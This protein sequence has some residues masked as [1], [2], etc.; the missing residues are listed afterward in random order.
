MTY[1]IAGIPFDF[2]ERV[3]IMGIL[4]VTPDSFSDG[5]SYPDA[6][7]A[8]ARGLRLAEEGA[9]L[10]D[11]GGESTRPGADPVDPAEEARRVVPVI[12]ELAAKAGVPVSVDTRNASVAREALDAG[13]AIV[14]DVSGFT[15]DEGM[16]RLVGERGATAVVMHMKGDPRTMQ[17]H[18]EYDDLVGEVAAFFRES[19]RLADGAGIRQVILDPGIGFGKTPAHNLEL[20][21]RLREF[22]RFGR[23][24]MV[25]P[26]RKGFI[27]AL[28]GLPVGERLEG[29]I[30]ACVAAAMNG[31]R[32][33][34]VHDVRA[35]SRAVRVA[36][37]V[38][39]RGAIRHQ[40]PWNYSG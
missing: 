20:L 18:P 27:G 40:E 38:M 37:A 9:D 7:A 1:T 11:V 15:H 16:A 31:A 12:R 35:V 24:L 17:E 26:S 32:I 29:T 19:L 34:R 13:A 3:R 22:E 23:P 36:E 8:V 6:G 25:G 33:L 14:N 4:N 10:I 21:A 2:S 28:L 39:A 5:G 30:G